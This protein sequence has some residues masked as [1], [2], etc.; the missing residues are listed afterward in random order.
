MRKLIFVLF[1]LS[2]C[3]SRL[4]TIVSGQKV[5]ERRYFEVQGGENILR[6]TSTATLA[7]WV[8]PTGEFTTTQDLFNISVGGPIGNDIK[9]RAGF[10]IIAGGAFQSVARADDSDEASNVT[11][12]EGLAQKNIWQHLAL[13][14]DYQE[15]KQEFFVNGKRVDALG[16]H[17]FSR[18]STSDTP[19]LRISL[20]AEDDGSAAFFSGDLTGAFAEKKILTEEEI[21]IVMKK[22]RP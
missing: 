6:N 17:V 22:T 12:S 7:L 2:S 1:V 8:R 13:T 4:P 14:I 3:S 11:T 21:Q 10:R 15:K 20:G 5:V 19:S 18:S 16:K 9:S